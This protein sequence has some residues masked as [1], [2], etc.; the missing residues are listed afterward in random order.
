MA[1]AATFLAP[2]GE[3]DLQLAYRLQRAVWRARFELT[4]A[5]GAFKAP[6][7]LAPGLQGH[8]LLNDDLVVD[9]IRAEAA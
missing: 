6:D 3:T 2:V 4:A 8:L 5:A 9:E 1:P 7:H